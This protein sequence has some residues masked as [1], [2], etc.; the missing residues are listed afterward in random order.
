MWFSVKKGQ[1]SFVLGLVQQDGRP[2]VRVL[3]AV[4]LVLM[5]GHLWGALRNIAFY[6]FSKTARL[7][8]CKL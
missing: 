4:T 1:V 5:A 8:Y 6:W 2:G 7:L 3:N